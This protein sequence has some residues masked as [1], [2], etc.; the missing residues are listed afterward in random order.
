MATEI[1]CQGVSDAEGVR[2]TVGEG[3]FIISGGGAAVGVESDISMEIREM[4]QF[5]F[6]SSI[7]DDSIY[8]ENLLST[9][10]PIR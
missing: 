1:A 7:I 3:S 2:G 6:G 8:L 9:L 10:D 5:S 4:L